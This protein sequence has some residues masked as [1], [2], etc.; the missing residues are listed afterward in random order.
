[1]ETKAQ[2]VWRK[3]NVLLPPFSFRTKKQIDSSFHEKK[4]VGNA[5]ETNNNLDRASNPL[6]DENGK[7]I[8]DMINCSKFDCSKKLVDTIL[9]T[10]RH[11]LSKCHFFVNW[12]NPV[13]LWESTGFDQFHF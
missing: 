11:H 9:A 10:G 1:M 7:Q 2:I 13:N 12:S 5:L 8:W 4:P 6:K 3:K